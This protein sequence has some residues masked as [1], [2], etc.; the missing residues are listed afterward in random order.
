MEVEE[1]IDRLYEL[2]LGEF[3]QARN[4][5]ER[6]LRKAGQREAAERVKALRKPTVT[7]A[8]VNRLVRE[9]RDDVEQFLRAAS[10]LRDAQFAGKGDL[11]SASKKEHEALERLVRF[12]GESARQTLLAAAVDD[13]AAQQ[14]LEARLEREIEPQGFGNLLVQVP[15]SGTSGSAPAGL[16]TKQPAP[17]KTR[18]DDT[19]ARSR[20]KE[21]KARLRAAEA[22][23]QH[24]RTQWEETQREVKKARA[25]LE[26]AQRDLDRLHES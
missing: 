24:A 13:E 8:R 23:E 12:G 25:V 11:A 6:G 16:E 19:E 3:T 26:K 7:A 1:I 14:L 18:P 10:E 9:H 15:S 5:A 22:E 21:A 4:E 2:P 17:E 20:L